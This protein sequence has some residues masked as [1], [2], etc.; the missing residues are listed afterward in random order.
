MC[1]IRLMKTP[2]VL[3]VLLVVAAAIIAVVLLNNRPAGVQK[4]GSD[5]KAAADCGP[6]RVQPGSQP[7][8]GRAVCVKRRTYG[9]VG[10]PGGQPPG[11]TRPR[12]PRSH[13]PDHELA[14]VSSRQ[15]RD[16]MLHLSMWP[17]YRVILAGQVP[18]TDSVCLARP[19]EL[20][21]GQPPDSNRFAQ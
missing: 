13:Q 19:L 4:I 11:V 15:S 8:M 16:I 20:P 5:T 14:P 6:F 1:L 18:D 12:V 9:S 17:N 3:V 10:T 2:N 7:V 21:P